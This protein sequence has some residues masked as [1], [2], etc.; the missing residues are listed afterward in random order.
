[1]DPYYPTFLYYMNQRQE[2]NE[3]CDITSQI[4]LDLSFPNFPEV[5]LRDAQVAYEIAWAV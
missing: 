5:D 1:M 3:R 2:E 4:L